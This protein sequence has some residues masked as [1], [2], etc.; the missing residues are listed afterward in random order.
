M[1]LARVIAD[2]INP[3]RDGGPDTPENCRW[4]CFPCHNSRGKAQVEPRV[5]GCDVNG[6][7]LDPRTGGT[8]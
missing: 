1:P 8:L 3:R 7:P 5:R 4:V 2:Y 6:Q